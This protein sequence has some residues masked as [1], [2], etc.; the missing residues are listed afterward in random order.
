MSYFKIMLCGAV[1]SMWHRSMESKLCAVLTFIVLPQGPQILDPYGS[2]ESQKVQL[3]TVEMW[4]LNSERLN[5]CPPFGT[6]AY[7]A[8]ECIM[9]FCNFSFIAPPSASTTVTEK[10][11]GKKN[12]ISLSIVTLNDIGLLVTINLRS[13]HFGKIIWE[14]V[15]ELWWMLNVKV[16]YWSITSFFA[17]NI[18]R[19]LMRHFP[20]LC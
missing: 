9:L 3:L 4:E 19:G 12:C 7:D 1:L 8:A 16:Q 5:N 2:S 14:K 20:M 18:A 17:F 11:F 15:T 6:A 13:F 10:V